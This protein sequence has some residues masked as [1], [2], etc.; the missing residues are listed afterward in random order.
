M[1]L[2]PEL[3]PDS[4]QRHLARAAEDVYGPERSGVLADQ[5]NHL[6]KMLARIS[7]MTLDLPDEPLSRPARTDRS[8]R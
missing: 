3:T 8:E 5:L 7:R 4:A 2:D 6:G 1:R